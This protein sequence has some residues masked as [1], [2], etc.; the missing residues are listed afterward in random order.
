MIDLVL[1]N[2]FAIVA[3]LGGVSVALHLLFLFLGFEEGWSI[4]D[5]FGKASSLMNVPVIVPL[6]AAI[7]DPAVFKTLPGADS[8]VF[9]AIFVITYSAF[10]NL[11]PK[12]IR[13]LAVRFSKKKFDKNMAGLEEE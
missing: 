4:W 10:Q 7:D 2:Y 3:V 13:A 6:Y 11:I 1:K 12:Y 5:F 9:L 8:V